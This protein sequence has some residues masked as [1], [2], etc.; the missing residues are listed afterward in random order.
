[1]PRASRSVEISTRVEPRRKAAR[2]AARSAALIW[3]WVMATGNSRSRSLSKSQSALRRVLTKIT[4]CDTESA[5]KRSHSVS[6]LLRTSS[7]STWYCLMPF[8][9][10]V[11]LGIT[12]RKGSRRNLSAISNASGGNVALKMP[13]FTS[14]GMRVKIS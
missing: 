8:R 14:G 13:T 9:L 1:M 2:T 11:S 10:I 6:S 4:V 12:I 7:Q 5:S 3:A